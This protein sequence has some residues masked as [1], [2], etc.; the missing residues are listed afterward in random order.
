MNSLICASF[1]CQL[2]GVSQ[3]AYNNLWQTA[4][5]NMEWAWTS[6]EN[7][8]KRINDLAMVKLQADSSF[9]AMK[10]KADA[11][12]SAGFGKLIGSIFTSDLSNTIGGSILG[13]II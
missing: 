9:N 5:D 10:F 13:K 12:S 3:S 11:D 2:L 1:F 7:E 6:A 8:R 4:S